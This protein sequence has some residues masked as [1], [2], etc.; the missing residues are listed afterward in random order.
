MFA[1]RLG[2]SAG[3]AL[4]RRRALTRCFTC[5][6][7]D[8]EWNL[9]TGRIIDV[10]VTT[11]PNFFANGL[12]SYIIIPTSPLPLA[13]LSEAN[14]SGDRGDSVDQKVP[15]YSPSIRLEYAPPTALPA[16]LPRNFHVEAYYEAGLPLYLAS[17][18]FVRHT[19]N[20][21]YADLGVELCTLRRWSP[22]RVS[23][24]PHSRELNV[25]IGL[26]VSGQARVTGQLAE[27]RVTQPN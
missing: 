19:L 23:S 4:L 8:H 3:P 6:I 9:R 13:P 25:S 27:W 16:P 24:S 2:F 21:L 17:A 1:K 26:L 11:L 10:L 20:A 15:L 14:S 12:T 22:P 18:M 5:A 7:S